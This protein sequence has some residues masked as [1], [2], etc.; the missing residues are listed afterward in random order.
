MDVEIKEEE[1]IS[2]KD[3]F[4][5]DLVVYNDDHND[6]LYVI[7]CFRDVLAMT[8]TQAEQCAYIIHTKGKYAVKTGEYH[9]LKPY[10]DALKDRG[11]DAKIV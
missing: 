10:C 6:I 4:Q 8:A 3:V 5:R 9:I 1:D 2:I 7:I 11:L